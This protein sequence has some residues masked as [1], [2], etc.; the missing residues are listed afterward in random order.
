MN[1]PIPYPPPP[2]PLAII[3]GEKLMHYQYILMQLLSSL[4]KIIPSQ[5]TADIVS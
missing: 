4:S 1:P 3:L 2:T 5:E